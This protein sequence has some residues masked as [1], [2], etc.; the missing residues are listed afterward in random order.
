MGMAES[1]FIASGT[2]RDETIVTQ[3]V[4]R[5]DTVSEATIIDGAEGGDSTGDAWV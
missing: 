4:G 2:V 1:S 3:E 5:K